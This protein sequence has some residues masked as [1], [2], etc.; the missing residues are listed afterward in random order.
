M[1]QRSKDPNP[2]WSKA[3]LNWNTQLLIRFGLLGKEDYEKLRDPTTEEIPKWFDAKQ[4]LRLK[5]AQVVWWDK[6]HKKCTIG[7]QQGGK[8]THFVRFPKRPQREN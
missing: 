7:G 2:A 3:T 6:T 8:A 4:M 5:M 1:G